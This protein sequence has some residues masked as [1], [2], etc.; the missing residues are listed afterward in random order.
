[1]DVPVSKNQFAP[2]EHRGGDKVPDCMKEV[3][4]SSSKDTSREPLNRNELSEAISELRNNTFVKKFPRTMKYSSDPVHS[5]Q[6]Y[7]LHTFI[8]SKGAKPDKDGCFGVIKIRGTFGNLSEADERSEQIIREVDSTQTIYT[9]YVG[10]PFPLTLKSNYTENINEV[11]MQSKIKE[12]V[13]G[14]LKMK[15]RQEKQEIN[16][17]K[18]REKQLHEDVNPDKDDDPLEIYTELQQ[19]RANILAS[20]EQYEEALK[21]TEPILERTLA[22]IAKLDE[23]DPSHRENYLERYTNAL[24]K[25]GIPTTNNPI[26]KFMNPA[27][28]SN[29]DI[30]EPVSEEQKDDSPDGDEDVIKIEE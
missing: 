22:L 12:I 5:N 4:S 20:R 21:K 1:M 17:I 24:N 6:V 19:K 13:N 2:N 30:I 29:V 14:D 3:L 11:D 7:S 28:S 10:K 23:D 18:E 27:I 25:V 16:E 9:G 15:R 26:I 8:P